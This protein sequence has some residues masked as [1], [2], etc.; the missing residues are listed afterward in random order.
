[1][2][3]KNLTV[4]ILI[5]IVLAG[6]IQTPLSETQ[7]SSMSDKLPTNTPM[8]LT[9]LYR[10]YMFVGGGGWAA[11][12]DQT[13][14]YYTRNFGEYWLNVTPK[15]LNSSDYVGSVSLAFANSNLGWV[16]QTKIDSQAVL[17]ATNDSGQTWE[18]YNLDFPCG[19]M[20]FVNA[21]EG[22]IVSDLGVGA[23][24]QYVSIY[25]T[26]DGGVT[27]TQVFTHDPASVENHG[28]P[29]SGI[30][31]SFSLL[32]KDTA[33][34]GG[35]RPMTGSLY[36]FRTADGGASWN[37]LTCDGLPDAEN[38]EL[39]PV[40]II[41]INSANVIVP[42]NTYLENG[43]GVTHYC[44]ST[45]AGASFSYL[46]TLENIE[47]TDFGSLS[48]GLAYG[49]GKM[50]QTSDGGITWQDVSTGLPIAVV[51]VSLSMMNENVGFLTATT[52]PDNLL[53]NRIYLT[54]NNGKDW[55]SVPGNIVNP[56]SK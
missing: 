1:M 56:I 35:S 32:D 20:A 39:D 5:M 15:E 3:I 2:K 30:K 44:V 55:Q 22:M 49:N 19:N 51:P 43:Q 23:G 13:E 34:I 16:C 37:Q 8:Y 40:D 33:L 17:Y 45:D 31:S 36:L 4:L 25:T 48:N 14:I 10:T 41:R 18:S 46:S 28:L 54:A 26:S 6:C 7:T 29:A 27:W 52:S 38:S 24:S 12:L 9:P 21:Q 11:N 42:V 50:M 53:Q 47:F